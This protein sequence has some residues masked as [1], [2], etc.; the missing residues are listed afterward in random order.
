MA[1]GRKER[2]MTAL[3][4][5]SATPEPSPDQPTRDRIVAAAL[6]VFVEKGYGGTR[7]Q[8]I[9]ERAGLTAG[10]LYVH[11]PNRSRLLSEAI[12]AEGRRILADLLVKLGRIQPGE[13]RITRVLTDLMVAE[14][15]LI[16]RLL[17]EAFALA[18]RD[19]ESREQLDAALH[20]LDSLIHDNVQVALETGALDDQLEPDAVASFFSAWI[21]GIIVHRAIGRP[22]P[23]VDGTT[24]VIARLLNG[25]NPASRP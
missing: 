25:L 12:V 7:V 18:S 3:S 1:A 15:V 14:P 4:A 6:E 10:A 19:E 17:V 22:R 16:D 5:D 11:F 21:M 2:E 13:L 9:A 20:R 8:D 24:E 23:A